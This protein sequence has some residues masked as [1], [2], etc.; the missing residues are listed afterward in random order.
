MSLL[1]VD[2]GRRS[3]HEQMQIDQA[4]LLGVDQPIL[5]FYDWKG[6]AVTFGYFID[7]AVWIDTQNLDYA[8]RP[9]GGGL[10]FHEHDLSFTVALPVEHPF[11]ALPSLERYQ[12]INSAVLQTCGKLLPGIACLLQNEEVAPHPHLELC[13]AHPTKYDLLLGG[14]K[15]GGASQ[16]K[17]KKAFIH[18]CSLFL[19]PPDWQRI[20]KHLLDR[21]ILSVLQS[22]SGSLF[23]SVKESLEFRAEVKNI[24][25]ECIHSIL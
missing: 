6:F 25:P 12:K 14:K 23:S 11:C 5:R 21:S 4:Y 13:M 3:S 19:V 8:R 2:S 24:L 22:V 15:V 16:R 18:Q 10:I 7:P 1:I 17:N 9:S 20:E